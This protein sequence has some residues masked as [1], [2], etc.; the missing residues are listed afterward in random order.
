MLPFFA[1]GAGGWAVVAGAAV[2][3]TR[4]GERTVGAPRAGEARPE[5]TRLA[6]PDGH[7]PPLVVCI[8]FASASST[9][10]CIRSS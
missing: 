8:A 6:Q 7:A 4:R 9:A 2:A 3:F 5:V 1:S 10:F